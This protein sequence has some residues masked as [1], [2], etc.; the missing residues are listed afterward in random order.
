LNYSLKYSS[1]LCKEGFEKHL[2][3]F[4]RRHILQIFSRYNPKNIVEVGCGTEPI[5]C[6]YSQC[7]TICIVERSKD[8]C[9]A[10]LYEFDRLKNLDSSY[11]KINISIINSSFED[12]HDLGS[13]IDFVVL[14]SILHEVDNVEIFLKHLKA[15]LSGG[16]YIYINVPNANSLH[17]LIAY[18]SGMIQ[19]PTEIS[20]RGVF[21]ETKRVFTFEQ[22]AELVNLCGFHMVDSGTTALKPF[23]HAQ[24]D[25]IFDQKKIDNEK[26][27]EAL[28]DSDRII[29]GVGSEIWMLLKVNN[30]GLI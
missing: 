22:L 21:F 12:C 10:A 25:R 4:R 14:S 6:W 3:D 26:L 24:M 8:F 27:F 15:L 29:P 1:D 17:R 9:E 2:V 13:E 16:E 11:S 19:S 7:E 18:H 20:E 5:F 30:N 23:T 28:F